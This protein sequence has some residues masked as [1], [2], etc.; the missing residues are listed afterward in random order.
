MPSFDKLR[1]TW[2]VVDEITAA[3]PVRVSLHPDVLRCEWIN[4]K[5]WGLSESAILMAYAHHP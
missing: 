3:P 2:F 1:M 5:M 4:A